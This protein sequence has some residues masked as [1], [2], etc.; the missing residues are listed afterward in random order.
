MIMYVSH[1]TLLHD[2]SYCIV[3]LQCMEKKRKKIIVL[4]TRKSKA[5]GLLAGVTLSC[6]LKLSYFITTVIYSYSTVFLYSSSYIICVQTVII[7]CLGHLIITAY[8]VRIPLVY[9][10][11]YLL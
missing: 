6:L 7:F 1:Q 9:S 8:L 11:R 2:N 10:K 4:I 3:I 5:R